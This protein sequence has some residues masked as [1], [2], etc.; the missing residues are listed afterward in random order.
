MQFLIEHKNHSQNPYPLSILDKDLYLH[1][2][3][4]QRNFI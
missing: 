3:I 1:N 4:K 2:M